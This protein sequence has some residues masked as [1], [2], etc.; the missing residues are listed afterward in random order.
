MGVLDGIDVGPIGDVQWLAVRAGL[1]PACRQ[2]FG[3]QALQEAI[4][5]AARHNLHVECLPAAEYVAEWND[6][7]SCPGDTL[8]FVAR[9]AA[10]AR[11][12]LEAE[13]ALFLHRI[14]PG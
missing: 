4:A 13:R 10:Q 2:L 14:P 7:D 5:R 9:N 11:R 12:A 8:I 3:G 1:K 6:A